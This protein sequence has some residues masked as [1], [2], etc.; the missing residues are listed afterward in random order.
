MAHK[1]SLLDYVGKSLEKFRARL[2]G[3]DRQTID[4][5]LSSVRDFET[6]AV[7]ARGRT[8][9]RAARR[10]RARRW[11]ARRRATTRR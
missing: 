10:S 4:S 11:T 5:H 8:S 7:G 1:K 9:P 2:G 3:D 6:P